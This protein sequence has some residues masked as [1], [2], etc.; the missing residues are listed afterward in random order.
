MEP[1]GIQRILNECLRCSQERHALNLKSNLRFTKG[2]IIL[3]C[4]RFWQIINKALFS[5]FV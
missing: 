4:P 5:E 3:A 1:L 2:L